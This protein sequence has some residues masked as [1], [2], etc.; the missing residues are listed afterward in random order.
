MVDRAAGGQQVGAGASGAGA[1]AAGTAA[2][3]AGADDW[4]VVDRTLRGLARRRA[5]LDVEEAAWLRR[6]RALG[7]HRELGFASFFE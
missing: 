6:A 5:A 4:R 3:A 7:V 2:A 1:A